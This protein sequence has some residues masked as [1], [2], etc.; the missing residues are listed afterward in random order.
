MLKLLPP[1]QSKYPAKKMDWVLQ[2]IVDHAFNA[3]AA[4]LLL[5]K[6]GISWGSLALRDCGQQPP[7][8][9]FIQQK[10]SV[11]MIRLVACT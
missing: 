4:N 5:S 10:E 1:S 8:A 9:P 11:I 3:G 2:G 7:E 6:R